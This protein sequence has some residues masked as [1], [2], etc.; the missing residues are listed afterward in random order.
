MEN[1][2]DDATWYL[3]VMRQGAGLHL[4]RGRPDIMVVESWVGAP[5]RAVPEADEWTFTRSV[6]DGPGGSGGGAVVIAAA[7]GLPHPRRRRGCP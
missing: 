4:V 1:L 2:A 6:R 5:S 3:G 7:P